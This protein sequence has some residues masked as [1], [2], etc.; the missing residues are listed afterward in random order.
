MTRRHLAALAV[1]AAGTVGL[2]GVYAT[3]G[4]LVVA[5]RAEFELADV[6]NWIEE[7]W[8]RDAA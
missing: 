3:L 7:H 8:L 1:V 6:D 2:V 5:R 4:L